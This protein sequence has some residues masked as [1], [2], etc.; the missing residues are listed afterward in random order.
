MMK[1]PFLLVSRGW[2]RPRGQLHAFDLRQSIPTI[3]VPLQ[4]SE[5]EPLLELNRVVHDL[6]HRVRFYLRLDYSLPPEPPLTGEDAIEGARRGKGR[7]L[8]AAKIIV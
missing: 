7:R 3:P 5:D 8:L 1:T 6:Y 4:R 2:Q